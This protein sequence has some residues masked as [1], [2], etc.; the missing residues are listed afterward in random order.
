M[1]IKDPVCVV[2]RLFGAPAAVHSVVDV[3]E[4]LCKVIFGSYWHL[5]GLQDWQQSYL[6]SISVQ[7]CGRAL[8]IGHRAQDRSKY[9]YLQAHRQRLIYRNL[10]DERLVFSTERRRGTNFN[11]IAL[12]PLQTT[13]A[14]AIVRLV[15]PKLWTVLLHDIEMHL[16]TEKARGCEPYVVPSLWEWHAFCQQKLTGGS[17]AHFS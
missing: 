12:P 15:H 3:H 10:L 6:H 5:A 4:H 13:V 9:G 7:G 17:L 2:L 8:A 1:R 16:C 11:N 14:F